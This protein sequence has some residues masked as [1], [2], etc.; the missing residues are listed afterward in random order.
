MKPQIYPWWMHDPNQR[1]QPLWPRLTTLVREQFRKQ[2]QRYLTFRKHTA[3]RE[4]GYKAADKLTTK[5]GRY[6]DDTVLAF[7]RAQNAADTLVSTVMG[8]KI[9]PMMG[10]NGG[11]WDDRQA[12]EQATQAL[13]SLFDEYDIES[14]VEDL[15]YDAVDAGTF[16]C[17]V[18]PDFDEGCMR[19]ERAPYDDVLFDDAETRYRE[20][21]CMY[22]RKFLDRYVC[23]DRYG[24]SDAALEGSARKRMEAIMSAQTTPDMSDQ[25][26]SPDIVEVFEAWRRP[27]FVR[28]TDEGKEESKAKVDDDSSDDVSRSAKAKTRKKKPTSGRHALCIEG[29]DILDEEYNCKTFPFIIGMPR[30]SREGMWGVPVMRQLAPGQRECEIMDGKFQ[31]AHRRMGGS[32]ILIHK[33]ANIM[34]RTITND[35]GDILE[36]DGNI[37][38]Q[39]WTPGPANPQ[40]YEYLGATEQRMYRFIGIPEMAAQGKLP[41]G[42]EQASGKA[43]QTFIDEGAKYLSPWFRVRERLT[44]ELADRLLNGIAELV[45][46]NPEFETRYKTPFGGWETMRWRDIVKRRERFVIQVDPVNALSMSTSGKLAIVDRWFDQKIID[47]KEYR[48]LSS[49]PDLR[50]TNALDLS[51]RQIIEMRLTHMLRTGVYRGPDGFDDLAM[52]MDLGPKFLRAREVD[53]V[54]DARLENIRSFIVDAK[55]LMDQQTAAANAPPEG[56][57]P[58]GPPPPDMAGMPPMGPGGPPP[59]GEMLPPD[60]AAAAMGG[61]PIAA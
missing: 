29:A 48:R 59:G 52:I 58:M 23:A 51:A 61:P 45:E 20:P 31:R 57:G 32:H 30:R 46:D 26:V 14:I 35:V 3:I 36:W 38:P 18:F 54:P 41:A 7:N 55:A 2:Q 9:L 49:I 5:Y 28:Y 25:E 56:A 43:L 40:S 11:D 27:T 60:M 19:V 37:P 44:R 16:Y 6:S 50:Q 17:K 53:G 33:N 21:L 47:D 42:L 15:L 13:A 22:E 34:K 12:A 8:A 24:V 4:Y 1:E 39:E 10:T